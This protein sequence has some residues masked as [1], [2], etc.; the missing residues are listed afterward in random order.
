MSYKI[1]KVII[2]DLEATCWNDKIYQ[3]KNSEIIEIGL[4]LIDIKN[5][6]IIDNR[7]IYIIPDMLRREELLND[8]FKYPVI[9][10]YCIKLTGITKELL[11]KR[12]KTLHE[13]IEEIKNH[14]PISVPWCSWGGFDYKL[15][16]FECIN[17]GISF[18]FKEE[19]YINLKHLFSLRKNIYKSVGMKKALEILEMSLSGRHHSGKDDAKNTAE[20]FLKII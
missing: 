13:G 3:D 4:A 9:S 17:K 18:P 16:K 11:I 1:N 12:G 6:S 10:N 8:R 20:I 19:N 15:L 2:I 14:Y 7:S 5:K